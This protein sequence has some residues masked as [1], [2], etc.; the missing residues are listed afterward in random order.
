MEESGHLTPRPLYPQEPRQPIEHEAG[1][2]RAGLV[3]FEKRKNVNSEIF[4][5]TKRETIRYMSDSFQGRPWCY[6]SIPTCS[7]THARFDPRDGKCPADTAD[8]LISVRSIFTWCVTV[9]A[10]SSGPASQS[11][12]VSC[13]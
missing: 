9:F 7:R 8:G 2:P 6:Y 5:L 4:F 1:G 10:R 13:V 11:L 3:G 12:L